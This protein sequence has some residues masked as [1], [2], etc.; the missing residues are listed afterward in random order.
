MA[1]I[2]PTAATAL[3]LGCLWQPRASGDISPGAYKESS[4]H[5]F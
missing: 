4:C 5:E 2:Y 3:T 1:P